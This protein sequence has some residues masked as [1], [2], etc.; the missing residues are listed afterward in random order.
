[1]A[2]FDPSGSRNPWTDFDETWH[3]WLFETPPHMTILVW[4]ARRGWSGQ[5]C[6]LSHLNWVSFL[7]F[8]FFCFLQ[9]APRSH[10]LTDRH[11]LYAKT[12][13]S[14]HGCAFWE[15][16]QY[17]TTFRGSNPLKPPQYGREWVCRRQIS[18]LVKQSS[19]SFYILYQTIGWY[20]CASLRMW[21]II[22]FYHKIYT[23]KAQ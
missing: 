16:R 21:F 1:M 23:Y 22:P 14:S 6:D 8:S 19:A 3:G 18:E 5:I 17:P 4:V 15:S 9:R 12:L 7:F 20:K 13:V 2:D 11:D 10:F